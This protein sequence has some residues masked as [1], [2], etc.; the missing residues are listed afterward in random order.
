MRLTG[1][2]PGIEAGR[3]ELLM[4]G[5]ADGLRRVTFIIQLDC[6]EHGRVTGVVERVGTG[7]K[8]RVESLAD[9][10]QVVSTM[11]AHDGQ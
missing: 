10:A 4:A 2:L 1:T 9:V 5:Q 7:E 6:A 11:L 3:K 8:A